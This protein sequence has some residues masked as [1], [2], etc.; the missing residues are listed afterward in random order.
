ML[1]FIINKIIE[2]IYTKN[3]KKNGLTPSGVFWNSEYNQIKR[4]EEL[5]NFILNDEEKKSIMD[6]G[7]GYGVFYKYLRDKGLDKFISYCGIDINKFLLKEC[8][9]KYPNIMFYKKPK[10]DLL[11]DYLLLSG[12]YNL[13]ITNNLTLWEKYVMND[14][15][16]YSKF[17]KKAI[18]MN[19]QFSHKTE[20][21]NNIYYTTEKRISELLHRRF[22]KYT[23]SRSKFFK[24]DI[25]LY[26]YQD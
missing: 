19:L 2:E 6:I 24:R 15:H 25:I 14:L 18:V 22:K 7:C 4:Y 17:C 16:Y 26:I 9:K 1:K 8:K 23:I 10:K 20:I 3:L 11:V 5:L 12:T 13:A 21:I